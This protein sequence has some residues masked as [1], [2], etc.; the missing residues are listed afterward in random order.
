M[1]ERHSVPSSRPS[2]FAPLVT[3]FRGEDLG[4]DLDWMSRHLAFLAERGVDGVLPLGTNGEF[5]SLSYRERRA[6]LDHVAA[7]RGRL[8]AIAGGASSSITET[9]ALG[10]HAAELGY[11]AFLVPP[12]FYFKGVGPAEIAAALRFVLDRVEIPV[13]LYDFP[14]QCIL[15][16]GPEVLSRLEDHPRLAGLKLS[17]SDPDIVRRRREQFPRI[18]IFVG[19]DHLLSS[20]LEAGCEGGITALANV[21]PGVHRRLLDRRSAGEDVAEDQAELSRWRSLFERYPMQAALKEALS[22]AGFEPVH[23]RPPLRELTSAEKES[24]RAELRALGFEV[25]SPV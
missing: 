18:Q 22:F 14:K 3:P 17:V 6:V 8:R 7:E 24:L 2:V 5:P 21:V 12:P 20:G 13:L 11:E 25:S 9:V 1:S 10:H 15:E 4:L 16:I 23:T 19:N